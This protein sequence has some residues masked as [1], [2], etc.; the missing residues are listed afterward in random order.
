M[1]EMQ[2]VQPYLKELRLKYK[3]DPRRMNQEV[4]KLYREHKVNPMSGCLPM[5]LQMPIFIALFTTLRNTI[6]LRGASFLWMKDLSL[7]DT[8]VYIAG[9]IPLNPLPLIMGLSTYWQQ[10]IS[11]VDPEQAKMMVFMPVLFTVMFY[12]FSSGLVL[13]WFVQNILTI[14]HQYAMKVAS[15]EKNGEK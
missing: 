10:K 5:L 12:N 14:G 2:R 6:E 4:M 13:Y 1:E 9:S 11:T 15:R 7:P 8:V 3:D